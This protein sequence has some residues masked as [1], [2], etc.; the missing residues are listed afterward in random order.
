MNATLQHAQDVIFE[1][2]RSAYDAYD[3]PQ[4]IFNLHSGQP[5]QEP[6]IM[7]M[8][9]GSRSFSRARP[10]L[11]PDGKSFFASISP[12]MLH[13]KHRR[14]HGSLHLVTAPNNFGGDHMKRNTT[15]IDTLK[16]LSAHGVDDSK[17]L[18]P[19]PPR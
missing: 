18:V 5:F 12:I 8:A 7:L 17:R 2:V 15:I 6:Q 19:K 10:A 14:K 13:M 9:I 11:T 16:M 3:D 1:I 4:I